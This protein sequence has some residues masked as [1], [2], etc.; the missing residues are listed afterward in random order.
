MTFACVSTFR[1]LHMQGASEYDGPSWRG[2]L[3]SERH[4]AFIHDPVRDQAWQYSL[5]LSSFRSAETGSIKVSM[6]D[7]ER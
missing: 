1:V 3:E 6:F 2:Q 7:S 5:S 4:E